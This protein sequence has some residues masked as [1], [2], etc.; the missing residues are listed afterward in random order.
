MG[1]GQDFPFPVSVPG[2]PGEGTQRLLGSGSVES[3]G[4]GSRKQIL[5]DSGTA[6][7][8]P[9]PSR[10][11][12]GAGEALLVPLRRSKGPSCPPSPR[13]WGSSLAPPALG[14]SHAPQAPF[15]SVWGAA[16]PPTAL[17][18]QHN[19]TPAAAGAGLGARQG[20]RGG[21]KPRAVGKS[22]RMGAGAAMRGSTDRA[23]TLHGR[24]GGTSQG[25]SLKHGKKKKRKSW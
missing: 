8:C 9:K 5:P 6:A 15:G 4:K 12:F 14:C 18:Q 23:G 20:G 3:S 19:P 11:D 13:H 7:A 1:S 25:G 24:I 2:S 10:M 21:R 16:S 17:I 22:T